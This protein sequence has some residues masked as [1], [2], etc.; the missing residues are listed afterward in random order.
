MATRQHEVPTVDLDPFSHDALGD[1]A[2]TDETL[3]ETGEVVWLSAHGIWASGRYDVV[4]RILR[5]PETF[6]SS[7]GTGITNVKTEENW[8]KPSV[9]LEND[10]PDHTR[11]R[12]VMASVL[13]ARVVRRLTEGFQ[14]SADRLVAGVVARGEVDAATDLAEA[15]PM[16][17]LPDAL[18]FA[19]EGR[20]HLLPYSTLNFNAAGPRNE[21]YWNALQAA[22]YATQF[23]NWQMRREAIDQSGLGGIIFAAADAGDISEEDAEMLVRTFLSAGLDTTIFGIQFALKA[24][25]ETPEAWAALKADPARARI[26]FE[27]SLRTWAPSPYI[28]RTTTREVEIGGVRMGPAQKVLLSVAAANHDPRRWERPDEFDITRDTSGHLTF[29]TGIHGC[30]GQMMA[31]MEA[32]C[33]LTALAQQAESIELAGTPRIKHINWLRGFEE[34]PMR[35]TPRAA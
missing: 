27:E 30:V 25:A 31:R 7:S 29:G 22:E 23:V 9:I 17:V 1:P 14:A 12:R 13:S 18:G 5:D 6:E 10:P 4:E 15:Y 21:L 20:E 11:Y 16:S 26:V 32:T 8:R 24:L 28:A 34:L 19:K 3:R 2:G 35:L 33:L